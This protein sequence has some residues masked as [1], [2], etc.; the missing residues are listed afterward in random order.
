M[1][2][3]TNML[4]EDEIIALGFRNMFLSI[5]KIGCEG[6][7]TTLEDMENW[8]EFMIR[9]HFYHLEAGPANRSLPL[10]TLLAVLW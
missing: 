10:W 2:S 1:I 5:S 4:H 6:P 7:S 8:L 3:G 9:T